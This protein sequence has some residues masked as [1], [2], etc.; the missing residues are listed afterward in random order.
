[1]LVS[2][3]PVP[4]ADATRQR[5]YDAV[6]A[7]LHAN[8]TAAVLLGNLGAYTEIEA[9]ALLVRP[10]CLV[11]LVLTPRAGRLTMPTALAY[12]TWQLNGQPLPGRGGADNPFAQ[13][14]QQQPAALAWLSE[15]LDVSAEALPSCLGVALFEAPLTFGPEVE[16]S[17]HQQASAHDFQLVAGATQLLLRFPQATGASILPQPELLAWAERL[18]TELAAEEEHVEAP[19]ENFL[20][21]KLRQLWRW[22]GAEDIPADPPYGG[23]ALPPS[24]ERDA[25]EQARL[26]QLRQELQA[27]LHQQRQEAATR[28]KAREQDLALLRQQLAQAGQSAA[29]RQAEQQAKA[30]LEEALRTARAELAARNHELDTRIKQ[31]GQLIGQLQVSAAAPKPTPAPAAPRPAAAP[32]VARPAV[33]APVARVRPTYRRLR[34]AER[35]G[36]VV[37]GL[38]GASGGLWGIMRMV[39]HP[40]PSSAAVRPSRRHAPPVSTEE[41]NLSTSSENEP[42]DLVEGQAETVRNDTATTQM[43]P[44]DGTEPKQAAENQ[45]IATPAPV[46]T[47]SQS[48]P[49]AAHDTT[50]VSPTP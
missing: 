33:A 50:V 20:E 24:H 43:V 7:A 16:A 14:R 31:L 37:L 23:P 46:D 26:Q 47:T 19:A 6:E 40:A 41:E 8:G 18:Q 11:L 10:D 44:A 36:L 29:E 38:A 27:E 45:P 39:R 28:E 35:W 12:G 1:M 21:Q 9:D 42:D 2:I 25:Q 13:Y 5:Q 48:A 4:F 49:P 17:L 30:A 15:Q 22:L 32:T 34:Q 3:L